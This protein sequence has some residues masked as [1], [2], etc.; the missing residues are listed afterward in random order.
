MVGVGSIRAN[1]QNSI[2]FFPSSFSTA[3]LAI[4]VDTEPSTES[5]DE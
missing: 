1:Q 5:I 4:F 3:E 2:R